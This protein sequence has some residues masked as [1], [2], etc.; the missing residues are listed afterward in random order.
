MFNGGGLSAMRAVKLSTLPHT[1]ESKNAARFARV[2]FFLSEPV[3]CHGVFGGRMDVF[4]KVHTGV[5]SPLF[6]N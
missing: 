3:M 1:R 6:N 2:F 4:S 5:T